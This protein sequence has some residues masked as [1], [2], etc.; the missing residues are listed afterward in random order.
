M[1]LDPLELVRQYDDPKDQEI[2]GFIAAG[3]A[4]GQVE[5]IR[6]AV[7]DV[8]SRMGNSPF[9]FVSHFDTQRDKNIFADFVYRFY[10]GRDIGL[11]V[12]M[13][14]RAVREFGSLESCFFKY[15]HSSDPDIGKALSGLVR[16]LLSYDVRPF[17]EQLPARGSGIR[18]FLADPAD[19]SSCK[20]LN[21][22]LRWM[23]RK[24]HLDLGV[25]KSV[26]AAKLVI[27]VDTHIARL[28]PHLGLTQRKSADWKMATE[29]T[30]S[31]RRFDPD[32][33]AKYDFA[34]CTIGKLNTCSDDPD[35]STCQSCPLNGSCTRFMNG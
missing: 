5:L 8:L 31:L 24:D 21:L 29:I 6:K 15:Y 26:S 9:A 28:A 22:Y 27:P 34:L 32:D 12:S 23:V 25:W 7:T 16:K 35:K 20:R 18:H 10:R 3:L 17:Y 1:E 33:P 13:M 4:I 11:L 14:A 30:E 19:G 2:A